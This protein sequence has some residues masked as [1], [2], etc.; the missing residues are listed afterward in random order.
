LPTCWSFLPNFGCFPFLDAGPTV[1]LFDL[2]LTKIPDAA[3]AA[4]VLYL[5][6]NQLLFSSI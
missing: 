2:M 3:P 6:L 1:V 4:I 5:M